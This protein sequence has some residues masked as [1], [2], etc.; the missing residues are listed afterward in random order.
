WMGEVDF[1]GL[2][3]KLLGTMVAIS[4]INLLE[5]FLSMADSDQAYDSSKLS[6]M[7]G[8]HA[9]FVITG[10]L[11]AFS[12]KI[13]ADHIAKNAKGRVRAILL[14]KNGQEDTQA[15][16]RAEVTPNELE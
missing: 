1:A 6:W 16:D 8:I 15:R 5:V 2:K 7:M 12:E 14:V 9:A 10:V 4:A 11:F 13:G 3:L